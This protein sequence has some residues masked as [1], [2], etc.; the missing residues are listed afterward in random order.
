MKR[1]IFL[2]AFFT[3]FYSRINSFAQDSRGELFN[4]G[5]RFHK[6][7]VK[8]GEKTS[9]NDKSWRSVQLPHDWSIE[10]PFSNEWASGTGY[11][12]GGIGWYRKSFTIPAAQK[13]KQLYLYFDGV[14]KNSEVWINGKYLGKRPNGYAS[15]YYDITPHIKKENNV[16]AVKVDHTDFADSRWYTGS[17]INRNVYLIATAPVHFKIWGVA[18]VTPSVTQG[19]ASVVVDAEIRNRTDADQ[20][21]QLI[22]ALLSADGT[23]VANVEKGINLP[24]G[25]MKT[26]V[27]FT[28]KNPRLWSTT[29]P[30]LYTLR[31][32]LLSSGK[33]TDVIEEPVGFRTFAFDSQSGFT[34]N[35]ENIKLK[36]V[37]FHDD[38][39]ALGS[40]VPRDVWERRLMSLKELGCN[41]IRMSHNPH[42]D[43]LYDLCDS[44]GFLV[45]DEAFDEWEIGKNKW[46]AGW[47]V[48]TPGKDGYNKDFKAWADNDLRDMILRNRNRAS[49]IMWSI[50]NEI[51]YPND[52]YTHEILNTGRN[53][54]IYG[55]GY[56]AGYPPASRLGEIS[57]RLV[58]VVKQYDT[59]RIVTAAL[60]GV[61]MSNTTSYPENLDVVGYNYQ[62]YRYEDDHKQYPA[63]VI[64]GSEN[65]KSYGAWKAVDDNAYISGQFLWTAFDFLGE[66]RAWPVRSSGAG[67]IDMAGFPKPEY[68]HRKSLWTDEPVIFLAAAAIEKNVEGQRKYHRRETHWNWSNQDS[69]LVECYT[70]AEKVELF[71]NGNSLGIKQLS[72]TKDK[73]LRWKVKYQPGEIAAKGYKANEMINEVKI[74]TTGN[75]AQIAMS[76]DKKVIVAN[77]DNVAHVE[78][79]I[80]DQQ[81]LQVRNANEEVT[82]TIDGPGVLIGLESGSLDSH[83]DYKS[84]RRKTMNGKLMAYIQA[85][86]AG[87]IKVSAQSTT[88]QSNNLVI[89]AK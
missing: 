8:D 40:A 38:A 82:V 37:C 83:E 72:E 54:Q 33:V 70:N 66:A 36:G 1:T 35:G 68:Y 2:I 77:S 63:R 84:N 46:I 85:T 7:D 56:Q 34:L 42:Q 89:N 32:S 76:V 28:V 52:P 29:N 23:M 71:L 73:I 47:N 20:K 62:E 57:K 69:V 30:T 44:M 87:Q 16:I 26:R 43:Y 58:S 53:P 86:G 49:I 67:L 80:V 6:G 4:S 60:A 65:S 48:G 14:Y 39:G 74:K 31:M 88:L 50:G 13:N 5:W 19:E 41:A 61:V 81:G 18:F 21:R 12:P 79:S 9:L 11:L 59:T 24:V 15:F 51:D 45:Q 78:I 25:E 22:I 27:T 75:A 10:G 64:Y 3:V 17:G 55:R